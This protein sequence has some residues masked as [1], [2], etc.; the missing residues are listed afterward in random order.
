MSVTINL[1]QAELIQ[2]VLDSGEPQ[3]VALF[4]AHGHSGEGVYCCL[5]GNLS[6][7]AFFLPENAQ[8][9]LGGLSASAASLETGT[10]FLVSH[11]ASGKPIGAVMWFSGATDHLNFS[12]PSKPETEIQLT[13]YQLK[14]VIECFGG[15]DDDP[16]VLLMGDERCHSGPGLYGYYQE[17]PEEGV[18]FFGVDEAAQDAGNAICDL[19]VESGEARVV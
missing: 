10:A 7:G 14:G 9:A 2:S 16:L 11:E 12:L 3:V 8:D 17:L 1:H 13:P 6:K 18:M 15:E 4:N 5:P 19:K